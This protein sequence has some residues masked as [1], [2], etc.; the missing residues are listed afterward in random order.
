MPSSERDLIEISPPEDVKDRPIIA[1][2]VSPTQRL[3][4]FLD[5][6]LKAIVT[7]L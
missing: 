6:L 3:S 7:T 1:G 2:P 5:N 4:E